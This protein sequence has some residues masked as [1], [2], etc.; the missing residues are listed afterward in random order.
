M[1][2]ASLHP[3]HIDDAPSTAPKPDEG[4]KASERF[5][6]RDLSCLAFNDRL[7]SEAA[8]PSV[9]PLDPLRFA[10]IVSSNLD[11][12]SMVRVAEISKIARHPPMRRFPEGLSTRHVQLT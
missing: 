4:L 12:F 3:L 2:R 6:N 10:T 11:E 5:F 1:A 7:L 8:N 9:P